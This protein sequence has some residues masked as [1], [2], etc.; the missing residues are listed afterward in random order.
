[1]ESTAL[2]EPRIEISVKKSRISMWDKQ[3]TLYQTFLPKLAE[4]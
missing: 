4:K 3:I 2:Q 1:M